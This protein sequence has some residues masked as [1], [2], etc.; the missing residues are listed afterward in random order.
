MVGATAG[1]ALKALPGES[2]KPKDHTLYESADGKYSRIG[3]CV[4]TESRLV[5]ARAWGWGGWGGGDCLA[6]VG[7]P[8]GRMRMFWNW[9]A[10]MAAPHWELLGAVDS[11]PRK[12]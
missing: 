6:G 8:F 9:G 1:G 10:V 12:W 5:I 7:F 4:G 2:Q 3:K 11:D